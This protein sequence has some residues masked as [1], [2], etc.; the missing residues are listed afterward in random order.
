LRESEQRY[1]L[2]VA[3]SNEGMWDWDMRNQTFFL[4]ARAQE[5]LGVESGEPMRSFHDWF[6]QFRYHPD[7]EQ[8]VHDA[9]QA[10]LNGAASHWEVEYR[11]YHRRSD[12]WRWFRERGVALRDE[13][14]RPY[15]MAG[16][17]D[18]ITARKNAEAERERLEA[19]LRQS[20]KIEAIGTLAGGIAHDF[21]N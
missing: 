12:S 16:S 17:L 5:L 11:F 8:R 4:S 20:Q 6:S 13:Q 1:Q 21:N 15:R 19:Q 9:M 3:G 2:A 10:Y 7:D 14:G 18:D